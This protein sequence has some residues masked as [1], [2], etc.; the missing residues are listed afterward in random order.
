M[1]PRGW[2]GHTSRR[3]FLD[4]YLDA[5]ETS[6]KDSSDLEK[7]M[8]KVV[9]A[10]FKRY[11]WSLTDK[12]EPIEGH[13]YSEPD[14]DDTDALNKKKEIIDKK[15]TVSLFCM[16]CVDVRNPDPILCQQIRRFFP[17]H[18]LAHKAAVNTRQTT[19]APRLSATP[20][21]DALPTVAAPSA[22]LTQPVGKKPVRPPIL[23]T[24]W[25]SHRERLEPQYKE[26]QKTHRTAGKMGINT[27]NTFVDESW[28]AEPTTLQDQIKMANAEHWAEEL[29]AWANLGLLPINADT[30]QRYGFS[31]TLWPSLTLQ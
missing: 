16:S 30:Q 10:Y 24:Y 11:H 20:H 27:W 18:G 5:Y 26:W 6:K 12:E 2:T 13:E 22:G 1:P 7:F 19:P 31:K 14:A 9:A 28:S 21:P 4:G 3:A 23:Q 17:N 29:D 25:L 15:T 8:L